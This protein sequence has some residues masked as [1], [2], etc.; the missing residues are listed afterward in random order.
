[1]HTKKARVV[2]ITQDESTLLPTALDYLCRRI[3]D[4]IELCGCVLLQGQSTRTASNLDA[5]LKLLRI[6]GPYFIIRNG[7]RHLLNRFSGHTVERIMDC[8]GVPVIRLTDGVNSPASLKRISSLQ[9]DY[10]VNVTGSEI[11][12]RPIINLPRVATLNLHTSRLPQYR[13][14][15]PTFW[16]LHE[17]EHETAVTVFI[18]D[19]GIDTG[20]IVV[21]KSI[22]I[23]GLSLVRLIELTKFM[24]MDAILEA[25]DQLEVGPQLDPVIPTESGSYYSFPTRED[26]KLF[27]KRGNRFF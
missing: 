12:R 18:V 11:F 15:L 24:G 25:I 9:P 3:V 17:G 2:L 19:E 26:V 22:K 23:T 16:A 1:M 27:K 10:L 4:P 6:F 5:L 14:M 20:P 21:Q 8:H 13:G 7:I